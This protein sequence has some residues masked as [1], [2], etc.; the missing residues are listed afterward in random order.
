M[1]LNLFSRLVAPVAYHILCQ[2]RKK[3]GLM[4]EGLKTSMGE[5]NG[6]KE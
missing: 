3:G 6:V 4:M 1:Y 2:E 5:K